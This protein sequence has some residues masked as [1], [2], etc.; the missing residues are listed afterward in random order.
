MTMPQ[1]KLILVVAAVAVLLVVMFSALFILFSGTE[2]RNFCSPQSRE[3]EA[4]TE[5]YQPVCG[6]YDPAKVQ[7][8]RYPCGR[9]FSNSCF[10][11]MEKLVI[12]WTDGECPE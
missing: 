1:R 11:C 3:F 12:Y 9:T 8:V 4:C 2:E 10:A 6:W 7:C 5:I